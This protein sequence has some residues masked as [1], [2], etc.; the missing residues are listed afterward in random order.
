[1]GGPRGLVIGD[2]GVRL[3]HEQH[4]GV[5]AV[6]LLAAT[7]ATHADDGQ[8]HRQR[9]APLCGDLAQCDVECGRN[10]CGSHVGERGAN[11]ALLAKTEQVG[12]RRA[13]QLAPPQAADRRDGALPVVA[14]SDGGQEVPGQHVSRTRGE[15]GVVREQAHGLGCTGHQVRDVAAATEQPGETL[16]GH[17]LVAQQP[18]VPRRRTERIAH[19]PERE[20]PGVGVGGVGEPAEHHRQQRALDRRAAGHPGGQRLEM[21]QRAG[22]IG[23]PQRLESRLRLLRSQPRFVGG[24]S[25]RPRRAAAGRRASRAGAAPRGRAAREPHAAPPPAGW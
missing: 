5:A 18:Q 12:H 2:A 1:M 16:G 24:E 25:S 3:V 14:A 17:A 9:P 20:Q 22:G 13:Q 7:E 8:P 10:G 19:L 15:L 21:P 4:V 11:R 6:A 23:V